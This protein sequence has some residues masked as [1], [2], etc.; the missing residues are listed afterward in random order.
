MALDLPTL[1]G[2]LTRVFSDIPFMF[3]WIGAGTYT[4]PALGQTFSGIKT[5]PEMSQVLELG[6]FDEKVEFDLFVPLDALPS[7]PPEG[8]IFIC[9]S[10]KMKVIRVGTSADD[11]QVLKLSMAYARAASSLRL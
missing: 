1:R 6:G 11:S 9:D 2:H 3:L 4:P 10:I 7:I 8:A 5:S